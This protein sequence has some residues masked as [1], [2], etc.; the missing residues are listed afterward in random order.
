MLVFRFGNIKQLP[1]YKKFSVDPSYVLR[2]F[3]RGK[4][5]AG[6]FRFVLFAS[7]IQTHLSL[8]KKTEGLSKYRLP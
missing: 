3:I 7:E 4:Y 2:P 6:Y 5:A 8:L 1:V